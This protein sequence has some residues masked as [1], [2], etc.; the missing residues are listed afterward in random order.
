MLERKVHS[1]RTNVLGIFLRLEFLWLNNLHLTNSHYDSPWSTCT[2]DIKSQM[3]SPRFELLY[4]LSYSMAPFNH[5]NIKILC[6]DSFDLYE[7]FHA[8]KHYDRY[9][10]KGNNMRF[11]RFTVAYISPKLPQNFTPSQN[12]Y[13]ETIKPF[14]RMHLFLLIIFLFC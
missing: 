14:T 11:E 12:P 6:T 7:N 2:H 5:F 1:L 3:E 4:P 10:C 8:L 9:L 13:Q